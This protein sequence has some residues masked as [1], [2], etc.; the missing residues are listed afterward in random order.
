MLIHTL[1]VLQVIDKQRNEVP[2]SAAGLLE[3]SV[4]KMYKLVG[5]IPP[6]TTA[7]KSQNKQLYLSSILRMISEQS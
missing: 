7:D 3:C 5:F 1:K 2:D 4:S 6:A